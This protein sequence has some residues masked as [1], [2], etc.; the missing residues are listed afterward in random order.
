MGFVWNSVWRELGRNSAKGIWKT[1]RV[2]TNDYRELYMYLLHIH[3]NIF[4]LIRYNCFRNN[5]LIIYLEREEDEENFIQQGRVR[6]RQ[7]EEIY[8]EEQ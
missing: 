3:I 1:L 4:S 2:E 5:G 8:G 6:E 7:G